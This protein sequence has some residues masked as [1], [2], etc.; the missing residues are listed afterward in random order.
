MVMTMTYEFAIVG[1]YIEETAMNEARK[2]IEQ[3]QTEPL[4]M[5]T[6]TESVSVAKIKEAL[7][8]YQRPT[9]TYIDP[10]DEANET[11]WD[12]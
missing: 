7:V 10:K 8:K 6:D 12:N 1:S 3:D 5:M 9:N 4:K 2:P 11:V